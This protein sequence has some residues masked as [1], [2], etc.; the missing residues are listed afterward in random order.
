[1]P[2][3]F[4]THRPRRPLLLL[5]GVLVLVLLH[6]APHA[7]AAE[8]KCAA[9]G[10]GFACP[11][12]GG[13]T[14][15]DCLDCDGY[16]FSDYNEE[17][18][19]DRKL[20]NADNIPGDS[21]DHYPFLWFDIAGT[22]LWFLTAGIATACGVGGGGIYV[23]MGILLLRFP[24]KPSS[25]LSQASIFGASLG[26]IL[27]NARKKHPD[28]HIRDT[29]GAPSDVQ[30]GK[31]VAYEKDKGPAEIETDR[32]RYLAGGDGKRK[33]YTRPVIDYDMAL[34]L[35]PMEMAGAVLGVVIQGLFPNWLFLSF[36]A[37]ILGFTSFKTFKKFL[38]TYAK[39]KLARQNAAKLAAAEAN[40][41]EAAAAGDATDKGGD[42]E[43]TEIGGTGAGTD[44]EDAAAPD[45]ASELAQRRQYLEEDARQ[46]PKGK[47]AGL[48]ILWAGLTVIT[49]LKGGKGAK[50]VIGITCQ[51]WGYYV[52]IAAQFLWTL[53]FAAVYGFK[54]VK[55]TQA[56]LAVRYPFNEHD[57]LW[58]PQKL[59]FYS[60]FTFVAGIVAGL[61]GIGGG[62]VLGPLMLVMGINP[63]VSTATTAT[64]I[65]L[66]SSSVAVMFVLS[67]LT[68]WQYAVYFFCI[69]L[70]GAYIGKTRIDAYVKKTGMGSVLVGALATIIGVATVGCII[71]LLTNLAKVEWC[72]DGFKQ[73]CSVQADGEDKC[74]VTRFLQ[75]KDMFLPPY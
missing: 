71:I 64:M 17:L 67:G 27:V 73:F 55:A 54:N 1:M 57:V 18:C 35:A 26:G 72:L 70:C 29:K 60:F 8:S 62:M 20:F 40:G 33:F 23:P 13:T 7:S 22:V 66:T 47:I 53:G 59:R 41:G 42:V 32:Q 44:D 61:I 68:P 15:G 50:S 34:F 58:D 65:L 24:P 5:L 63:R 45:D 10:P 14:V 75:V 12:C 30:E 4:S 49:F 9:S 28:N 56:R 43:M 31:I 2:S 3:F 11:N 6:L 39:D 51:D 69:C 19:Y 36:A 48:V 25:G 21:D 37:V 52:L 46:Y 74:A 16:L 38:A